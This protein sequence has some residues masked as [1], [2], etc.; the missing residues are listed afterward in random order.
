MR[1]E[2]IV[3]LMNY[4]SDKEPL[5]YLFLINCDFVEDDGKILGNSPAG[6][7][8]KD[9]RVIFY[10]SLEQIQKFSK[11]ELYYLIIHEAFHIL[12]KHH[13]RH[14]DLF[15]KD[16]LVANM[17]EDAAINHEINSMKFNYELKANMPEGG[18]TPPRD[19]LNQFRRMGEDAIE[20]FRLFNWMLQK[21][22][23]NRQKGLEYFEEVYNKKTGERGQVTRNNENGTF[24]VRKKDGSEE[25]M[26]GEDL[27]PVIKPSQNEGGSFMPYNGEAIY[28]VS[29]DKHFEK[30]KKEEQEGEEFEELKNEI[31]RQNFADNII[32]Q[33][34]RIEEKIKSK[35]PGKEVGN[36]TRKIKELNKPKVNWRKQLKK[37]INTFITNHSYLKDK[38]SSPVNYPYDPKSNYGI[39]G[40]HA[41]EIVH[42]VTSYIIFAID[43]SGSC[44][45]SEEEMKTFFTEL[46]F[47]AKELNFSRT[48]KILTMQWDWNVREGL[49]EYKRGSWK[50]YNLRGGGGTNPQSIFQYLTDTAI[51][52]GNGY[53]FNVNGVRFATK[54][55]KELPY[56]VILTDGYFY[57]VS[58]EE[59]GIY[60]NN[61]KNILWITRDKNN[62]Y[63]REKENYIQY[64]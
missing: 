61:P 35:H 30:E 33:A 15:K 53:L 13:D 50:D 17:A 41:I 12:K 2:R 37:N 39:L 40:K 42:K 7:A 25:T 19:F 54:N 8:Y 48:G 49:K 3:T 10:Y 22:E 34:T 6:V 46:D 58:E 62:I 14:K 59:L 36:L 51:P 64:S 47:A 56:L 1:P 27:I 55:K 57:R 29:F 23:E 38:V 45:Y 60:K 43:T 11:E 21:A 26:N 5:I 44:F 16:M 18:I 31:E 24:Q 32:E 63:P 9:R 52:R 20:S 4:I 28:E